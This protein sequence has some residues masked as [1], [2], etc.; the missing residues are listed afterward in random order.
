M[1]YFDILQLYGASGET[2]PGVQIMDVELVQDDTSTATG[3]KDIPHP[4]GE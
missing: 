4:S 1:D 3:I 2:I